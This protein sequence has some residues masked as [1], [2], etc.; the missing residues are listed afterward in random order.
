M[1]E[2]WEKKLVNKAWIDARHPM[3]NKKLWGLT[4]LERN[5]RELAEL[6]IQQFVILTNGQTDPQAHY[7]QGLPPALS[8]VYEAAGLQSALSSLQKTLQEEASPM[9]AIEGNALNDKRVLAQ[10]L[11]CDTSCA[12]RSPNGVN[13][14]CAAVLRSQQAANLSGDS[15][16]G[17]LKN[18]G[19]DP[20]FEALDLSEFDAYVKSL[21]RNI[22]PFLL[23]IEEP[24]HLQ[25][26]DRYLR[27]T[28]H[29]GTNDFVASYIHP[30]LEFAI[31]RLVSGTSITPNQ[32]TLAGI[33]ISAITVYLFATGQLLAGIVLAATKGVLD[34]VDGKLARLKL[35]FSK[36][37]DLLDHISD[38]VFD[39]LWYLALGWH[40]SGGD[41]ASTAATF[42][43]ILF[44]SYWVERIVPG[45]FKKLHG[46]EIY[47]YAGIDRFMRL[48]GSR[49][50]N[51]VWV[52]LIGIILGFAGET[53]YLVSLW[54]LATAAWHTFRMIQVT[55]MR[56][57]AASG[58]YRMSK[59]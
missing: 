41:P 38:T 29:K 54:M 55:L 21:R 7:S 43:W 32:I 33:V 37:G 12:V 30:P 46:R 3:C 44:I 34:G 19:N 24:A 49:M 18:T 22:V 42:T 9:V 4:L 5:I 59:K 6:G 47:D 14:A 13:A 52:M 35:Q 48:I 27:Q 11:A 36:A 1:I 51:N 25:E 45:V 28:V 56:R 15:L 23:L 26:A 58:K 17:F 31:T 2:N 57:T 40:F 39:A 50:N 53:F 8:V 16:T 10:L 20:A